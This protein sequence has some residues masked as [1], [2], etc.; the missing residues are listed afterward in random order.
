MSTAQQTTAPYI[1]IA[2]D[3]L[4]QG[5]AF[6]TT[7]P[8]MRPAEAGLLILRLRETLEIVLSCH[9]LVVD[10]IDSRIAR[11]QAEALRDAAT[12]LELAEKPA[13]AR[14]VRERI[15]AGR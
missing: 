5:Q 14:L 1:T 13:A 11:G 8:E 4:A 15:P 10:S 2:R 6:D 12:A 3:V 9:E 7:D